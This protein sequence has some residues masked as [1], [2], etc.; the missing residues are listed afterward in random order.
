MHIGIDTNQWWQK[1]SSFNGLFQKKI[2][3]RGGWGH[4]ISRGIEEKNVEIPGS[5]KKEAEFRGVFK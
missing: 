4:G 1:Y 3:N 5:I 2:L